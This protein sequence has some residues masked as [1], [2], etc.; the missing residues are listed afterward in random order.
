LEESIDK[1]DFNKPY[2]YDD[3]FKVEYHL[4]SLWIS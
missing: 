3:F 2:S 1:D 4:L